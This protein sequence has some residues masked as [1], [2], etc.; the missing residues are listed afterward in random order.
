[1]KQYLLAVAGALGAVGHEMLCAL[2]ERN[3]PIRELR[4]LD[5]GENVGK[6]VLFRGKTVTVEESRPEAFEG[7]DIALFAVGDGVSRMLAPEAVKRGCLVIDNSSAWRMDEGTPL[8]VPEVNPEALRHHH[9]IIA[10]PNCSTIIAMVPLKQLYD[11]VG[12]K[13]IIASTYQ[14]VSGAGIA[15]IGELK[16]QTLQVLNQEAIAPQV[17]AH[18]IAFNLIPHIDF[19]EENAYTHEE[20]KMFRE[21]GAAA[22]AIVEDRETLQFGGYVQHVDEPVPDGLL[23][24]DGRD[25]D[26]MPREDRITV[27]E[28]VIGTALPAFHP[29]GDLVFGAV[30]QTGEAGPLFGGGCSR[31]DE[32]AGIVLNGTPQTADFRLAGSRAFERPE[33]HG[34]FMPYGQL[35]ENELVYFR[36]HQSSA[37]REGRTF[38]NSCSKLGVKT[39]FPKLS[40]ISC[41][42]HQ[43]PSLTSALSGE[44]LKFPAA[45]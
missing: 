44:R 2:E 12:I 32:P 25:D 31:G 29:E 19:F 45:A 7:V 4:L 30:L 23:L 34:D 21:G 3:F 20:M 26:Q 41:I 6:D 43:R 1:M 15:G 16:E 42:F 10:N 18:Q 22:R 24:M 27:D 11:A 36:F 5:V 37:S 14:A 9:G 13:R 35:V 38:R 33:G 8:V 28:D 40:S 39:D 17:F